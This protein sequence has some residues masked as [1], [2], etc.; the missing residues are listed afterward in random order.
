MYKSYFLDYSC[1]RNSINIHNVDLKYCILV[2][3]L[4]ITYKNKFYFL[5]EICLFALKYFNLEQINIRF[6]GMFQRDV[7]NKEEAIIQVFM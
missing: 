5:S 6:R 4:K 7:K 1:C 2:N 3:Y